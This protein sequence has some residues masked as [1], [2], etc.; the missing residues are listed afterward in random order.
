MQARI[1]NLTAYHKKIMSPF[2]P[3]GMRGMLFNIPKD[4]CSHFFGRKEFD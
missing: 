3:C 4:L 1:N 2:L